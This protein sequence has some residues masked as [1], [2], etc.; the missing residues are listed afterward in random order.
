MKIQAKRE[1]HAQVF[2]TLDGDLAY[3]LYCRRCDTKESM[4]DI[5]P[6]DAAKIHAEWFHSRKVSIPVGWA[7]P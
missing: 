6:H 4:W 1:F 5:L 7:N 3:L 2:R